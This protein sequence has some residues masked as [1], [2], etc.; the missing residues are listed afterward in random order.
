M[1]YIREAHPTDG[2]YLGEGKG[3]D[4]DDPKTM[5]ERRGVAGDCEAAMAYG[6]K[7][8]VDEMDDAV[9]KAYVAWPERLYL[10]D[11]TGHVAY[12]GERGPWGFSP[13]ELKD[14]VDRIIGGW[15][16]AP[17]DL[18]EITRV[19]PDTQEDRHR[20]SKSTRSREDHRLHRRR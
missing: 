11:K 15:M 7:T 16:R 20:G 6:I 9:M 12:A 10:V 3:P 18:S 19:I 8:Y 13:G 2:W 4:L 5:E 17:V 1:I 14:A